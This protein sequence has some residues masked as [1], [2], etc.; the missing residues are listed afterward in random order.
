MSF[1]GVVAGL[2][3]GATVLACGCAHSTPRTA[4]CCPPP[5]SQFTVPTTPPTVPA[6]PVPV[7]S[8]LVSAPAQPGC[9]CR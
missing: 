3:L 2:V 7:T 4:G 9:N 6:A 5:G 8:G 1:R